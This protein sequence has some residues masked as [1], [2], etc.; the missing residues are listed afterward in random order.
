MSS[1][2]ICRR[3]G[4]RR[5]CS[6][7]AICPAVFLC[8]TKYAN[9]ILLR[10]NIRVFSALQPWLHSSDHSCFGGIVAYTRVMHLVDVTC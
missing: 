10:F 5:R 9:E 2:S 1:C 8:I 3:Y 6:D 4:A 7:W